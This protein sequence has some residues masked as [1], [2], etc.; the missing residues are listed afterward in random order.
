MLLSNVVSIVAAVSGFKFFYS[1][2][3]SRAASLVY[4]LNRNFQAAKFILFQFL[5]KKLLKDS[6]KTV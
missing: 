2:V 3:A 4:E 1:V 5:L 6:K